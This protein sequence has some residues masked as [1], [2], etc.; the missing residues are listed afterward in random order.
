MTVIY[1][2]SYP[3]QSPF[4]AEWDFSIFEDNI[5]ALVDLDSIANTILKNEKTVINSHPYTDD[6]GTGLGPNSM[7]SR[8]NCYNI[9][10]WPEMSELKSNIKKIYNRFLTEI[11]V[12]VEQTIYLQ[13]WANVLRK[14]EFIKIH[15]HSDTPYAYLGGHVCIQTQG[16]ST[17]YKSPFS[18]D[19]YQ[20][21]NEPGKITLFPSWLPHWTSK[22]ESE[23][24]RITVAFDIITPHIL[25]EIVAE[26][27]ISHW[28]PLSD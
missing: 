17:F 18:E 20:S 25:D 8:S 19:D 2:K 13:C 22:Q 4:A 7:T 14:G 26:H 6:W 15:R 24:E 28:V 12:P 27:M 3:K 5:S 16:S 1:S 10:D 9:L 23:T 11:Q 21:P